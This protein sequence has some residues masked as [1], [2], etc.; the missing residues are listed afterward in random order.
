[1]DTTLPIDEYPKITP[2]PAHYADGRLVPNNLEYT[3]ISSDEFRHRLPFPPDCKFHVKPEDYPE[4][5]TDED[6]FNSIRDGLELETNTLTKQVFIDKALE[7][8]KSHPLGIKLLNRSSTRTNE[9]LMRNYLFF[10]RHDKEFRSYIIKK[11][12][13][14]LSSSL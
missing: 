13:F 3:E 11:S 7:D 6:D 12:K 14:H 8:R 1:V 10:V 9:K 2:K 4:W 5:I